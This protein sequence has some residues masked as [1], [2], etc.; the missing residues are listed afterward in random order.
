LGKEAIALHDQLLKRGFQYP[1][2]DRLYNDPGTTA[3]IKVIGQKLRDLAEK[4]P[5][6]EQLQTKQLS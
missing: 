6:E 2:L 4:L 1:A 5:P 3:G